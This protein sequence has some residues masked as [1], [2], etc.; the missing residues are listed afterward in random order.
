[1]LQD[2]HGYLLHYNGSAMRNKNERLDF[3]FR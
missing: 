3:Q 1:M 2:G